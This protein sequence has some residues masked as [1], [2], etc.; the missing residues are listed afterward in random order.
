MPLGR[1]DDL[2]EANAK[3]AATFALTGIPAPAAKGLAVVTCID[4]RIEPLAMLGLR[5]G[6]A[7]IMRNAGAR[8]SPDVLRS[9]TAA[10]HF[11]NVTRVALVGHT[12]CAMSRLNDDQF[13]AAIREKTNSPAADSLEPMTVGN[14]REVFEA[15]AALI[16]NHPL[17]GDRVEV[18]A[19]VYDVASG[20][21]SP[22]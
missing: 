16:L 1:F 5:P 6:D 2:L 10:V 13:R 3:Y 7:K 20:V 15:D 8:V 18:G 4:S 14:Q 22:A 21:L 17:I 12:D 19:F 9:L 11:L